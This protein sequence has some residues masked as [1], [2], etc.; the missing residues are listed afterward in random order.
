MSAPDCI[1]GYSITFGEK[2]GNIDLGNAF[3]TFCAALTISGY[4]TLMMYHR[5][6]GTKTLRFIDTVKLIQALTILG[7]AIPS[8]LYPYI[9]NAD[10]S[11]ESRGGMMIFL[12]IMEM[13]S[14]AC[15]VGIVAALPFLTTLSV[16]LAINVRKRNLI[17]AG[18]MVLQVALMTAVLGTS[19]EMYTNSLYSMVFGYIPAH[20]TVW[21]AVMYDGFFVIVPSLVVMA[22]QHR[23]IGEFGKDHPLRGLLV[24]SLIV[25][26]IYVVFNVL[27]FATG[28]MQTYANLFVA[29]VATCL[30]NA[31]GLVHAWY[32]IYHQCQ[33]IRKE[34][35][36]NNT[37]NRTSKHGTKVM[38]DTPSRVIVTSRNDAEVGFD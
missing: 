17:V 29:G 15:Y 23:K 20:N 1:L 12:K 7:T 26:I 27:T 32:L 30:S 34:A 4:I 10:I 24:F 35:N 8:C 14:I 19:T 28:F 37:S 25:G 9:I 3:L 22:I 36:G 11:C 33:V 5:M 18:I 6:T 16:L 2:G 13:Y 38:S 21:G 31:G